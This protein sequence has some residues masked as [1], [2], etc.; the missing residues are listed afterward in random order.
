MTINATPKFL[1]I[2][3]TDQLHAIAMK[4]PDNLAQT[5]TLRLALRGVISLLNVKMPYIENLNTGDIRRLALKSE[6]LIWDLISTLYEEQ[7]AAMTDYNGHVFDQSTLKG[8]PKTLVINSLVSMTQIAADVTSD[9]NCFCL[10]SLM[11]MISS[12]DTNLTGHLTTRAKAPID[13]RTLAAQWMISPQQ[14]QKTITVTA[15]RCV[16]TCLNPSMTHRYPTN[17]RMLRY[18][19]LP[20]PILTNTMFAGTASVGGNK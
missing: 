1:D 3:P 18:K 16:C 4:D 7:E 20:H 19:R 9:D 15:Q 6:T 8:Q 13:F 10:L 12:V 11:I 2:D 14:A 17:D 5:L